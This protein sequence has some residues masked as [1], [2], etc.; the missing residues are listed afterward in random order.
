[1]RQPYYRYDSNDIYFGAAVGGATIKL[2]APLGD[3][4]ILH[5]GGSILTRRDLVRRSAILTWKD[6]ITLL[7][8]IDLTGTT[9][10]GS[11]YLD[12]GESY[13]NENGEYVWR[14][15][16]IA[17]D[18]TAKGD[19][20]LKSRSL[21]PPSDSTALGVRAYDPTGNAWAQKI[22]D[23]V[24]GKIIILGLASKPS[25]IKVKGSDIGL[26]F[27]WTDGV[28]ATA[29]RRRGGTG[30][31]ASKLT[32]KDASSLIIQD[33]D[34]LLQFSPSA[35]CSTVPAIDHDALVASPECI[36]GRFL[37]KNVGHISSCILRSRFN[38][39]VCDEECCDGSDETDGKINCPNRCQSVGAD[40]RKATEE[41]G[42]KNRVGGA[43]RNDYITFGVKERRR[44]EADVE[45]LG[46][47]IG[48]LEE[49]E[50]VLKRVLEEV[51]VSQA[52]DIER[53]KNSVLFER[54]V[55]MQG[56]IKSL[57]RQRSHLE[58]NV[59][60]LSSILGDLSVSPLFLSSLLT[61]SLILG[62]FDSETSILIIKTWPSS[63]LLERT[64]IGNDSTDTPSTT[65]KPQMHQPK[66]RLP[67]PSRR[68]RTRRN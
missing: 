60:D 19:L 43:V 11:I 10:E 34:I 54:I 7:A 17:S 44:M 24:V 32:I 6:P 56:A 36:E 21:Q 35:S 55:E 42:R 46:R 14:G 33:W 65:P 5:R 63:V 62:D 25:C 48:K 12:D 58:T 40:Y 27:D 13:S 38:D 29:G 1:M 22:S 2:P 57:R 61:Q 41:A 59:A 30:K 68:I 8:A 28:A 9:A 51:E 39:G 52:G 15:F 16:K 47:D 3:L 26:E 67:P 4:P 45:K 23:V 20:V 53:K 49:R 18:E 64:R 50:T 66:E 37:C 31:I